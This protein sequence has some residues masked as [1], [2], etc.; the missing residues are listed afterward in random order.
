MD[1]EQI[2]DYVMHT[3]ANTNRAVLEDMIDILLNDFFI[4]KIRET[5]AKAEVSGL[6]IDKDASM[7]LV[8]SLP[9]GEERTELELRLAILQE[10]INTISAANA[11]L[12]AEQEPNMENLELAHVLVNLLMQGE[13]KS[14]LE[15]RLAV[16]AED[17]K[18][19]D[20]TEAV[21]LA[22]AG[23][24]EG[25]IEDRPLYDAALLLVDALQDGD[26]KTVLMNRLGNIDYVGEVE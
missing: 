12:I 13:D 23:Q 17:I 5:I 15:S 20:A 4:E 10:S 11:V 8:V 25:G 6:Q 26:S 21:E 3:P 22:E 18:I 9:Y 14:A 24:P 2:L 7:S 16:V 1:K 19:I